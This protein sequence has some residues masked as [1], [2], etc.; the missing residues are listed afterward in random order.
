MY[1]AC[2][3]H[4]YFFKKLDIWM[5]HTFI[6]FLLEDSRGASVSISE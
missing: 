5:S 6:V 4:Q 3:H 2:A 1:K